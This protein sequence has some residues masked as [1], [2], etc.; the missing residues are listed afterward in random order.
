MN[1][2]LSEKWR[3]LLSIVL[4]V[5][6]VLFAL[7]VFGLLLAVLFNPI[8][9]VLLIGGGFYFHKKNKKIHV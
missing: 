9:I 3:K 5:V 8:T 6:I 1:L 4:L 7:R 2:N